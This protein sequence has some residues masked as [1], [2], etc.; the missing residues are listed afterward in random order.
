M[1]GIRPDDLTA[2]VVKELLKRNKNANPNKIDDFVLGC[3][4]P[5]GPRV[6]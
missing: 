3:A 2:Q 5:E 4:F 1:V 6:C